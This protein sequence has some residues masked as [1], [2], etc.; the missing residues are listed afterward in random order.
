VGHSNSRLP[1][2]STLLAFKLSDAKALNRP[3]NFKLSSLRASTR[4]PFVTPVDFSR[5]RVAADEKKKDK[6]YKRQ[7]RLRRS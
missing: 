4:A 3:G 6:I 7:L 1:A 5:L 2:D